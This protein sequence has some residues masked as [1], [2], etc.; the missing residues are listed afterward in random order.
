MRPCGVARSGGTLLHGPCIPA[1]VLLEGWPAEQGKLR[2]TPSE[3]INEGTS[4]STSLSGSQTGVRVGAE[5]LRFIEV[6]DETRRRLAGRAWSTAG[7]KVM[8]EGPPPCFCLRQPRCC[9]QS[10]A[11]VSPAASLAPTS[12]L[13]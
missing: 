3:W 12:N 1:G 2:R 5:Q 13:T 6:R 9:A 4:C 7:P 8:V 10:F 11:K